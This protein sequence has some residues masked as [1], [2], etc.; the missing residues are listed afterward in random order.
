MICAFAFG[1]APVRDWGEAKGNCRSLVLRVRLNVCRWLN[2][3]GGVIRGALCLRDRNLPSIGGT[4]PAAPL[5]RPT[6]SWT[7]SERLV[8]RALRTIPEATATDLA[9]A[10]DLAAPTVRSALAAGVARGF[11]QTLPPDPARFGRPAPRF[12]YHVTGFAFVGV[13]LDDT[14]STI[15]VAGL[16]GRQVGA[17]RF[18]V[19]GRPW[20]V[21]STANMI[22]DVVGQTLPGSTIAAIAYAVPAW[23]ER[24]GTIRASPVLPELDGVPL[25]AELQARFGCPVFVENNVQLAAVGEHLGGAAAGTKNY[26]YLWD[27]ERPYAAAFVDGHLHRGATGVAGAVVVHQLLWR[28]AWPAR[29]T[30]AQIAAAASGGEALA[31]VRAYV[32]KVTL[33]LAPLTLAIDPEL[34]VLA[35]HPADDA[36]VLAPFYEA[37]VH[38]EGQIVHPP[39]V[40]D[41]LGLDARVI[42]AL[43]VA[44]EFGER[45]LTGLGQRDPNDQTGLVARAAKPVNG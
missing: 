37:A 41:A 22:L 42:G 35:G 6:P 36:A 29:P 7:P 26:V 13:D 9:D 3:R 45:R 17:W 30:S 15:R 1:Q 23:V 33:F 44:T 32:D 43:S 8:L 2:V 21:E 40:P 34:I 12:A 24:N 25:V 31:T 28:E 39:V 10:L 16:D 18:P 4:M 5:L 11:V 19:D 14:G 20:S 27:G 38:R